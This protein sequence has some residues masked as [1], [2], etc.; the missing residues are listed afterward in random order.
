MRADDVAYDCSSYNACH[1]QRKRTA[2]LRADL[3]EPNLLAYGYGRNGFLS[4]LKVHP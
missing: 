4:W 1:E 3:T 2:D